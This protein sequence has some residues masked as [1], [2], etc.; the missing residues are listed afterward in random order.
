MEDNKKKGNFAYGFFLALLA[1][2]LSLLVMA[3]VPIAFDPRLLDVERWWEMVILMPGYISII[4]WVPL[5]IIAGIIAK[6][7]GNKSVRTFIFSS[8]FI[9]T[10]IIGGCSGLFNR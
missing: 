10:L 1:W 4:I 9:T 8:F 7:E 5:A 3:I 2:L 6:N